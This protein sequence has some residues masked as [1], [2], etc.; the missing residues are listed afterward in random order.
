M[1]GFSKTLTAQYDVHN[2]RTAAEGSAVL[3]RVGPIT[4]IPVKP[5]WYERAWGPSRLGF[6]PFVW[7][8][9]AAAAAIFA[10]AVLV[11][12]RRAQAVS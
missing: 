1:A 4:H 8:A 10:L 6:P 11:K 7:L 2:N 9:I 5:L 3:H 12:M